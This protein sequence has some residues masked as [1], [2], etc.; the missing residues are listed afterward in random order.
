MFKIKE[1]RE[2]RNQIFFWEWNGS[3]VSSAE[4]FNRYNP[5]TPNIY[6]G[7]VST[8]IDAFHQCLVTMNFKGK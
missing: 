3:E 6:G 2:K 5:N 7:R 8:M 4:G 1:K